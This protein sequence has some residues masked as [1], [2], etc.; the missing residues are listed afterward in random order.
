[1]SRPSAMSVVMLIDEYSVS[2]ITPSVFP[3]DANFN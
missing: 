3:L 1:M 2:L